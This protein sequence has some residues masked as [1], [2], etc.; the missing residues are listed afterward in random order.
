MIAIAGDNITSSLGFTTAE[1]Y[2]AAASGQSGVRPYSALMGVPEP[3]MA[4]LIDRERL[5]DAFAA[6]CPHPNRYTTLEQAAILSVSR[7][8]EQAQVDLSDAGALFVVSSTKGNVHLLDENEKGFSHSHLY[9]WYAAR[10]IA[11]YFGNPNAPLVVSNACISGAC[12]QV[13]AMRELRSGLYTLAVVVGVEVLSRFIISGF[14]SLKALSPA[15][16]RPFDVSRA[17]LNLGEAAAT[18]IYRRVEAGAEADVEAD[19]ERRAEAGA[20]AD[21]EAGVERS[22]EAGAERSAEA[23]V[24][25]G[26]EAGAEGALGVAL[27]RG[28]IRND[29]NHISGPSRTGEGSFRALQAVMREA[30]PAD[31]AFVNAHGTATA[32]NDSMEAAAITRAGLSQAPVNSLKGCFGHT[33]GAAGVLESVISARALANE[34]AL[35]THGFKC[36]EAAL[37]LNVTSQ[38]I[39]TT[40][41]CC[42]KMLSGFGGGNAALLFGKIKTRKPCRKP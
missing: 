19:V 4:A 39:R 9:L 35:A 16:C 29:A 36:G 12:A 23:D 34:T 18:I 30:S 14:Q 26:A 24:E 5:A 15:P 42:V 10:L 27:L 22:A 38:N 32:Y 25:A 13:A 6:L 20:E 1:N 31:V 8:A 2:R 33:L 41:P 11:A 7:A 37:P 40:K 28:A 3:L 17:G 21:V